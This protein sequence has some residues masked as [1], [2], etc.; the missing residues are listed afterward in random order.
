MKAAPSSAPMPAAYT[1]ETL[2]PVIGKTPAAIRSLIRRGRLP[3]RHLGR[4]VV[5]L[6]EDLDRMLAELPKVTT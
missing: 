6:R 2:A 4:S 5:V 1:V 3:A